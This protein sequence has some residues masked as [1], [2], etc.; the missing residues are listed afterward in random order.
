MRTTYVSGKRKPVI[1]LTQAEFE[2]EQLKAAPA[3]NMTSADRDK[4]ARAR[5]TLRKFSWEIK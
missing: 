1:G 5:V 4:L 2:V 3:Q